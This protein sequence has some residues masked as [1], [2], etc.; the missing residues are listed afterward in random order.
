MRMNKRFL[1]LGLCTVLMTGMITG[2]GKKGN[3]EGSSDANADAPSVA[4]VFSGQ[5]T[6]EAFNQYTYEGMMKAK[7]EDGI[8]TAYREDVAQDEQLEVI[9]QFAQQKFDVIVAQGGQFGEALATVAKEFPDQQFIFSVGTDTYGLDNMTAATVSYSHAGY[10][11]GVMAAHATKANKVAMVTGEWYD[12]Q[13]QME[14]GFYEGVKSVNPDIQTTGVTT[15]S[16]SD[17]SMARE[18]SLALI[19][20][21][22]DILFFCLDA[23]Y[24]GV[25]S[26]AQDSEGVYVVGSVVD[27]AKTG[28]EVAV[29][30]V[31]Y[32]WENLGYQ[33]ATGALEK[34]KTYVLGIE[35][36]G[37]TPVISDNLLSEEGKKA[38]DEA[39]KGLKDGTID[40]AP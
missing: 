20:D 24:V 31:V 15:G 11:A 35:E 5:I 14:A 36:G 21:G 8:K 4:M 26:A 17:V 13:R 9:R 16:W 32:N 28:P 23:A 22:Y 33:E 25:I 1:A 19:A 34:G 30:S 7:E 29:G 3:T 40:L 39:I 38:V 2:C 6:D 37:I 27:A 18:A 10:M 12:P